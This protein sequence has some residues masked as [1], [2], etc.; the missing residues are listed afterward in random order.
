MSDYDWRA[1]VQTS[2]CKDMW[3]NTKMDEGDPSFVLFE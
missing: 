1:P 3:S 2:F